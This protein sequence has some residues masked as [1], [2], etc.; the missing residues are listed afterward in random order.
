MRGMVRLPAVSALLL[1]AWT[2]A[3]VVAQVPAAQPMSA[4]LPGQHGST[5]TEASACDGRAGRLLEVGPG[6]LYR[7]V[8]DAAAAAVSGDTV[9]IDAGDYLGDVA[10]WPQDRLAICGRGGKVRLI[11]N[12]RHAGGK[13]IWVIQ[14]AEVVVDGI[15]FHGA[16]VPD[17]NGAGIRA[18]GRGL[19]L[20]RCGFY[21]NENGVLGPNA[22]HLTVWRSVFGRNGHGDGYSH[23]LYVGTA[24]RL[25]VA[26]SYFHEARIGHH[27]KSRARVNLIETSY[28]MDGRDGTASYQVDLPN[29]GVAVL[30]GNLMHKGPRADNRAMLSFGKEGMAAGARHALTLV[31]NTLVSTYPGG[32]YLQFGKGEVA[33]SVSRNLFGG[34]GRFARTPG[35]GLADMAALDNRFL[36]ATDFPGADDLATPDFWPRDADRLTA[37]ALR[38]PADPAYTAEAPRPLHLRRIDA[39]RLPGALQSRP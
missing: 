37:P 29:G 22:G 2:G 17:A 25:S 28:F 5:A 12:G 39:V 18:E 11:A 31:H 6:R 16:A 3:T 19:T 23:N 10:V 24:E 33:V 9:L 14:G 13:G 38:T 8:R 26:E 21:D 35:D 27:L 15:E 36:A 20:R 1:C 7:N 4:F 34:I 32:T 30:R